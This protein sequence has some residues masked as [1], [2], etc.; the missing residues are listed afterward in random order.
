MTNARIAII[1]AGLSGLYA[2]Y[3]L[4]Q[5]GCHDYF[6]LEARDLAGGRIL[7]AAPPQ[8][9]KAA[10]AHADTLLNRFDLGPTWFWPAMQPELAALVDD[11]GLECFEQFEQG[12]MLI[13]RS[14]NTPAMR[15]R[16]Y[17]NAPPSMRL[18]GGMMALIEALLSRIDA[19]KVLTGHKLCSLT[20]R[21]ECIELEAR[22]A[23]AA[24]SHW[25]AE[26]VLLAMPPRLVQQHI[27]FQ[28]ALPP[29]LSAQWR[30][31]ATWMA[32][33]AKYVA[34]YDSA[35]WRNNGLSGQARSA[36]G[37]MVEIH[38]AS[39]PDGN[40][41]LFGF[42]GVPATNRQQISDSMMRQYCRAQLARLF[43]PEAANPVVEFL[44]DWAVDSLTATA[45][46]ST[47]GGE[48]PLAPPVTPDSGPWQQRVIGIASEWSPGFPGYL[49]GAIEAAAVGVAKIKH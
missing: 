2:A 39:M 36:H 9:E 15:S 28:P 14:P 48:H 1:G 42:I 10:P 27:V 12:D 25:R 4:E 5:L 3:L 38:D 46:D 23:K 29:Q 17:V 33:H 26:Y 24:P 32:P 41:A 13:E 37:P 34:V 44:K 30:D 45:L 49:A 35:F 20:A 40:A 16:G 22:D 8:S 6:I 43:G 7:S 11:L 21:D 18:N 31:T 19:S 47:G